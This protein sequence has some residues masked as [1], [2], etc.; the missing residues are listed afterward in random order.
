[1]TAN[2]RR[3]VGPRCIAIVGPFQSGKTALFQSILARTKSEATGPASETSEEAR[4]HGHGVEPAIAT[5]RFMDED[6][7]FIDCPGSIEFLHGIRAALPVCDAAVVVCE[8]DDKKLSALQLI[9]RELEEAGVPRLLFLNKIDTAM[10]SVQDAIARLQ[11]ASSTPLLVRQV[12]LW[13]KGIAVGFVDLALERAFVYREHAPSEVI[14]I[15]PEASALEKEARFTM[16]ERLA[17][18]DDVLMEELISDIE[19]PRDQVFDDLR[20]EV[21]EGL[22]VPVLIGAADRGH[23]VGRLLKAL[24]HDAPGIETTRKRLDIGTEGPALAHIVRTLHVPHGGKVS[25]ARV[26]RGRFHEGDAVL[27]SGGGEARIGALSSRFGGSNGRLTEA[28][29]GMTV[30]FGRLEGMITS[31]SFSNGR[32]RPEP[33]AFIPVP[34]P[35]QSIALVTRDPKDDVRLATA[36]AKLAEEDPALTIKHDSDVRELRLAGQGEVH[37]KVAVEKLASRYGVSV[38]IRKPQVGYHETIRQPVTVR[39][40]HKKQTGGHGQFGDVVLKVAPLPR[41][42]GFTFIDEIVGGVVP[43]QF[44]ASVEHGVR[45]ALHKGPLGCPVVDLEVRLVDGSSHA[46]DSSDM[47]FRAA[48]RLAMNEAFEKA[49]SILLEPVHAVDVAVPSDATARATTLVSGR[50]GQIL[51]YDARPGWNG[52]DVLQALIPEAE[53]GNFIVELRSA[54]AGVGSFNAR[55]DHLA[56]AV[57]KAIPAQFRG[58]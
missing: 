11:P 51:G 34:Q 3:S 16:L 12:P 47:A 5:V 33:V 1:M 6:M 24:R 2:G 57:G 44:I 37:L 26:L 36:L 43:R 28:S 52:W 10:G 50:R 7:T 13:S 22:V 55:F 27:S 39:G 32:V 25:V 58:H 54:T 4:S 53:L 8:P 48:A 46:V 42:A 18:H 14:A 15:P 17:D 41:G 19:P 49:G 21:H 23:G 35:V 31:E 45:E 30:G 9:L 40:R 56:E 29:E 20:R 38:E